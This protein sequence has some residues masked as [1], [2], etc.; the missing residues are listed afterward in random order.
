MKTVSLTINGKIVKAKKGEKVLW[1][2]LDNDIYIPSLCALRNNLCP[3]SACRL[4]FIEVKG[5]DYP[6]LACTEEVVEGMVV[7]TRGERALKLAC[8]SFELIM[9]S[10]FIDCAHCPSNGSCELQKIAKHLGVKLKT[11]RF[12]KIIPDL[13]IDNS[14]PILTYDPKRCVL[15]GRC[16]WVCNEKLNKG[17]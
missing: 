3:S 8:T 13:P 9:A 10:H 6:V 12:R 16:V 2:A 5:K 1:V 7:N 15:C 14:N 17:I 4:C 11:N